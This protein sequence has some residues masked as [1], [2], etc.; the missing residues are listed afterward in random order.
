MASKLHLKLLIKNQKIAARKDIAFCENQ[1]HKY[2][3]KDRHQLINRIRTQREFLAHSFDDISNTRD[4]ISIIHRLRHNDIS[5]TSTYADC[6]KCKDVLA[7]MAIELPGAPA[8]HEAVPDKEEELKPR[9]GNLIS[10]LEQEVADEK[11]KVESRRLPSQNDLTRWA[12]KDAVLAYYQGLNIPENI[13]VVD[14][15]YDD[16]LIPKLAPDFDVIAEIWMNKMDELRRKDSK[17]ML[18]YD[19]FGKAEEDL[20]DGMRGSA[21]EKQLD[22]YR[23]E[24]MSKLKR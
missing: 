24:F 18:D 12:L 15:M 19:E 16:R 14:T 4:L 8:E 9:F 21:F 17:Y 13:V 23:E 6:L 2:A 20:S 1:M 11:N 7:E 5:K 10:V 22:R 3:A